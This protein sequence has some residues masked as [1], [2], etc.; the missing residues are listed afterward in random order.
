[1]ATQINYSL[2]F[3]GIKRTPY[4]EIFTPYNGTYT[5]NASREILELDEAGDVLRRVHSPAVI[6]QQNDFGTEPVIVN[7]KSIT[8]AEIAEALKLIIERWDP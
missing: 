3:E 4:I 2:E 5:I 6:K 1:M 7:G 8:P